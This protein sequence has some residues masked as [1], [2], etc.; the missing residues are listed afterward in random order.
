MNF[1][2]NR[3]NVFFFNPGLIV[4]TVIT[5]NYWIL[6][7]LALFSALCFLYFFAVS[8]AFFL[9][10]EWTIFCFMYL[11][12]WIE[13]YT[14]N[15]YSVGGYYISKLKNKNWNCTFDLSL[16][17]NEWLFTHLINIY[18]GPT[19]RWV[20]TQPGECNRNQDGL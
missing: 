5:S 13:M 14:V 20:L 17:S 10:Q 19:P 3:K 7:S 9:L 2:L 4:M 12:T 6:A 11:L 8:F 1:V 15:F 18:W 16:Y